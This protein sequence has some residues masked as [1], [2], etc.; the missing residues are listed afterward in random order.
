M[1]C[2]RN[3]N[4]VQS[5]IIIIIMHI[6]NIDWY[7]MVLNCQIIIIVT[8]SC[9]G[10]FFRSMEHNITCGTYAKLQRSKKH[11]YRENCCECLGISLQLVLLYRLANLSDSQARYE[12]T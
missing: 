8:S 12:L 4:L 3:L 7:I 9:E 2:A 11:T 6:C 10:W 5:D 1:I